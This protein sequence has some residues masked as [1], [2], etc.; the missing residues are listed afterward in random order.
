MATDREL[1]PTDIPEEG[2]IVGLSRSIG[3]GREIKIAVT[4]RLR[5][6]YIWALASSTP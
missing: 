1:A 2:I 5:H 6:T 3:R 4:D